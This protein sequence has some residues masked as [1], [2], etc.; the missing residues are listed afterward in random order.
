ME[1][2]RCS[3]PGGLVGPVYGR[4]DPKKVDSPKYITQHLGKTEDLFLTLEL[5][6]ELGEH[7]PYPA[8]QLH[9][10]QPF[11]SPMGQAEDL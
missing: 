6:V 4:L 8:G 9:L 5:G 11:P 2:R 10:L 1:F 7:R 3:L